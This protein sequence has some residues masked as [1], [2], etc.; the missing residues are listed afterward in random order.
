MPG[1]PC[2]HAPFGRRAV[3]SGAV[4]L[5]VRVELCDHPA[6]SVFAEGPKLPG[7]QDKAGEK[8][9]NDPND[10]FQSAPHPRYPL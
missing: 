2:T 3:L 7:E 6:I 5:V 1:L 9:L 8:A 10:L 4:K